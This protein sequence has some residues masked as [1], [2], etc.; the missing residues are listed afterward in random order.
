MDILMNKMKYSFKH[1][2]MEQSLYISFYCEAEYCAACSA[3]GVWVRW[4][5]SPLRQPMFLRRRNAPSACSG[6]SRS[7]VADTLLQD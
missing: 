3:T 7:K 4:V 5:H 6:D 1:N 2:L